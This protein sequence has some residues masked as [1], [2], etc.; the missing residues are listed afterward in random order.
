MLQKRKIL[1]L[2][3]GPAG[4]PANPRFAKS[5][6]SRKTQGQKRIAHV[7]GFSGK[8]RSVAR[9]DFDGTNGRRL[10]FTANRRA[11]IRKSPQPLNKIFGQSD[12]LQRRFFA[13]IGGQSSPQ[14]HGLRSRGRGHLELDRLARR[15]KMKAG[16][17]FRL[18]VREHAHVLEQ[19]EQLAGKARIFT[20]GGGVFFKS[21]AHCL[22]GLHGLGG[23]GMRFAPANP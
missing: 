4:Q 22:L 6:E 23:R 11:A 19:I 5:G 9:R 7:H 21:P 16:F 14:Q 17:F 3:L 2:Q 8:G 18:L 10:L 12:A 15:G 13:G 20:E 1:V